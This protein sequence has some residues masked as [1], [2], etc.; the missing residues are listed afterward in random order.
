MV[1]CWWLITKIGAIGGVWGMII[2]EIFGLIVNNVFVFRILNE[3]N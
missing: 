2:S 1:S 3:G